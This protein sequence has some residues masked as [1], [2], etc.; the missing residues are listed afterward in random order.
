LKRVAVVDAA[1]IEVQEATAWYEE[2]DPRVAARFTS[3]VRRTL[4]LIES[5]PQIGGPI[6]GLADVDV[7]RMSVHAFPYYLVFVDYPEWVEVIAC[8]HN[9][10]H[11]TYFISRLR[12][13]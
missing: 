8:A 6:R 9:R 4:D 5:F 2:R 12:R 11:P 13:V 7:R 1:A 10:R 3:E